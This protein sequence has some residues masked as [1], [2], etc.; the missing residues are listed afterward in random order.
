MTEEELKLLRFDLKCSID[1]NQSLL[2][3]IRT[4]YLRHYV[5]RR[6]NYSAKSYLFSI[7]NIYA[8]RC[9]RRQDTLT[10]HIPIED[11]PT[12]EEGAVCV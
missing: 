1:T 4:L 10:L 6:K 9:S 5:D 12:V 7:D 3:T 8:L 2:C 11:R